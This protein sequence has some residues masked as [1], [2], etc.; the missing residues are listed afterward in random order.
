MAQVFERST[1]GTTETIALPFESEHSM[2]MWSTL[3]R[4]VLPLQSL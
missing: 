3:I 4:T 2:T 1:V